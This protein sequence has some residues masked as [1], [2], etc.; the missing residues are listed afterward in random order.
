MSVHWPISRFKS[1]EGNRTAAT[2]Q[3]H[4]GQPHGCGYAVT[5]LSSASNLDHAHFALTAP[6]RR[7]FQTFAA[8]VLRNFLNTSTKVL[9]ASS[10]SQAPAPTLTQ[11]WNSCSSLVLIPQMYFKSA[12]TSPSQ[13][14]FCSAN[15]AGSS[16]LH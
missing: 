1:I 16:G 7:L 6:P 13:P 10:A 11:S 2:F 12:T 8:L 9:L 5:Q 4:Q 3:G 15:K 14:S